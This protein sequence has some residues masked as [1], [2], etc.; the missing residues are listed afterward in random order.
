MKIRRISPILLLICTISGCA[1]YGPSYKKLEIAPEQSWSSKDSYAKIESG[2]NLADTAWWSKF[3]DKDLNG[4][5]ESA[6]A[7]NNQIQMAIGNIIQAQGYLQQIRMAWVPTVGAQGSYMNTQ[8]LGGDGGASHAGAIGSNT[9]S[10]PGYAAGIVPSY[11]INIL[12]QLRSQEAAKAA[13][14]TAIYAKDA[15][16]LTIIGQVAGSYFTLIGQDYQLKLQK[17]LVEDTKKQLE[18]GK[19]QYKLGYI[20]LLSLQQYEQNYYTA[21]TQIP[22]IENNIVQSQNALRVLTNQ[23]PGTVKRYTNFI[24]I[25]TDGII[26]VGLPSDV[27]KRRPDIMQAEEQLKQYNANIGVATSAFFPTISLTSPIGSSSSSL[28]NLFSAGTN[29]WQTQLTATMPLLNLSQ[30]GTVKS[31]K[32]QYYN[33]YYNYMNVVRSAFQQVDNSL[34]AHQ[35]L[36]NSYNMQKSQ[37]DSAKLGY[38]IGN[39]RY[40]LGADSYAKMLNYKINMDN[41]GLLLTAAKSQQLQ[42][43]VTLYQNLAGGYNVKNTKKPKKFNDS[44]DA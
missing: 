42:S 10:P 17:E 43:I 16:R 34:S 2:T 21:K 6:L 25:K 13:L 23:Y 33:S 7:N 9:I 15:M 11:T 14:M 8:S 31:A 30:F 19:E 27:L 18:L 32:G 20:S 22:V 35:K 12:Q 36:A 38:D 3:S 28:A 24:D 40:K 1:L 5:I 26:P 37:F 39:E 41:A 29:F 44:H 4:L